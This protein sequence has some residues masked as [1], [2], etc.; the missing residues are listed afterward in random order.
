MPCAEVVAVVALRRIAGGR[1]EIP[2]VSAGVPPAVG[3]SGRVVFVIPDDRIR[4]GLH[5]LD[6][7]RG[8]VGLF[9]RGSPSA[10]VLLVPEREDRGEGSS[11]Q[12][13]AGIHLMAAG[14]R[15]DASVEARVDRVARDVASGCDHRVT[16]RGRWLECD[17]ADDECGHRDGGHRE[18]GPAEPHDYPLYRERLPR[19][20]TSP[21]T[22]LVDPGGLEPPTSW[23]PAM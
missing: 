13:G 16:G 15:P 10:F 4:D 18:E 21:T 5:R 23:L 22:Q 7:P 1:T 9:E 14:G 3:P 11:D 20:T 12:L 2:E 8:I 19:A 17:E 6:A